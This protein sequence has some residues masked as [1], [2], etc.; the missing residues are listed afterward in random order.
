MTTT[1]SIA[2]PSPE[3]KE[4]EALRAEMFRARDELRA[5]KRGGPGYKAKL[6]RFAHARDEYHRKL[7]MERP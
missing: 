6:D 1:R 2:P 4:L 7:R 5:G 3:S